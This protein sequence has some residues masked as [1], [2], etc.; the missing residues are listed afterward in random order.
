[1]IGEFPCCLNDLLAA[2]RSG[3]AFAL[4]NPKK[5]A[6]KGAKYSNSGTMLLPQA[7]IVRTPSFLEYLSGGCGAYVPCVRACC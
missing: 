1:L 3:H 6:K 2:G 4:I 5:Q 7:R